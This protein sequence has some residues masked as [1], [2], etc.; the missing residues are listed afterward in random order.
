MAVLEQVSLPPL[1]PGPNRAALPLWA[2]PFMKP[3]RW[4]SASGG[5]GSTKSHTFA[6]LA[7]L[8][9][10]GLLP[11]YPQAPVR[12]ASCRSFEVSIKKSVK[13]AVENYIDKL[14]L[15]SEFD[16]QNFEIYHRNGSNM[17]FPG[18]ARKVDSFLSMED[19]DVFWMEQAEIL[20][21]E[22]HKIEPTMR[23]PGSELWFSW[24]PRDR[25][26]FCWDRFKVN[27]EPHY[28]I[29]HINY[30]QNPWWYARCIQCWVT[31]D[32]APPV[33]ERD[34]TVCHCGGEIWPGLQELEESRRKYKRD[35]P[36]RYPHEYLGEPDDRSDKPKVLPRALL[37]MCV[38][39]WPMRPHPRGAF[40]TGGLDVADMG[41]DE[42]VLCLRS[43]PEL[44]QMERWR[45]SSEWTTSK[46]G[47]RAAK[48]CD[49]SSAV[50][51]TY[52]AMGVGAGIRGP[53]LEMGSHAFSLI[54]A[55]FG[56]TPQGSDMLY[57]QSG[58]ASRTN[59][60]YFF[61]WAAQAGWNLRI[62]AEQTQRL[63]KG[64]PHIDPYSCL[65]I[66]PDLPH[67]EDIL[68][69]LAQPEWDDASGKLKINKKPRGP[70]EPEPPSPDCYDAAIMAFSTDARGGLKKP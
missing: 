7:V 23:K 56:G 3:A 39:A 14:G 45:G 38:E 30:D 13:Q 16:V 67:L 40:S 62:K 20:G 55:T 24:N 42:N 9:M 48:I 70:G 29:A 10:A 41:I 57:I 33:G 52:D 21:P 61:N 63:L 59:K 5:R 11:D 12:I 25:M 27:P 51:L 69:Q 64:E 19:L 17:F 49:D 36:E 1:L 15:R 47:R 26:S 18:V 31:H 6:Q 34:Y 43:G 28:V 60:E 4:K 68:A 37:N 32:Y 54:G 66:N 2:V 65:F 22:M 35:W 8:R 46:T 50:Y 53:V 44:Y 58:L